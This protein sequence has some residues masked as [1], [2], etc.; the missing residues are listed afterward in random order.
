MNIKITYSWLLEYLDTDAT[1]ADL[2]KYLSLSGPSIERVDKVDSAADGL[3]DYVFDIE[4]TT[5]RIDMASVFGIAQ[6]A[7]AIMPQ[8]GFK[9]KLRINP[10][11]KYT[12]ATMQTNS[13]QTKRLD[14]AIQNPDLC[15]RFT[16]LIFSG[17]KTKPALDIVR[18]RLE[19]IGIKSINNVIDISNYLMVAIGQPTHMF[20]Y[21]K[22]SGGKMIVRESKKGEKLITLDGK[23]LILPGGDIV[24]ED[25][26]GHLIDLCGIMGG[27]N[28]SITAD[29]KTVVFFVQTYDK[30]RLRKT[31]MLTGQRTMA[32]TYFEKGLDPERVENT[33]AY[34]TELLSE[35]TGGT[36]D[37]PLY[38]IYPNPRKEKV[39]HT[40]L[41]DIH[42]V[43]GIPIEE[44]KVITILENLGF[45]VMRTEDPELA[46][47][48]G[49]RLDVAVPT[50]R[51]D[52]VSIKEDITEE[53]ARVYGYGNLPS[54]I[55]PMV[56]VKQPRDIE[57]LFTLQYKTKSLFKY[58]GLNEVLNYSMISENLIVNL[59]LLQQNH[60]KLANTISKEIEYLRLS[61]LPS[62]ALNMKENQGKRDSL[63]FF[64][65]AKVYPK[66]EGD[67]PD[68][69]YKLG[70]AVST[71]FYDLKGIIE[72]M[73]S[74]YH[75]HNYAF[76][77]SSE[78]LFAPQVQAEIVDTNTNKRI[79]IIGKLNRTWKEGM[80][81]DIDSYLAELDFAFITDNYRAVEPYKE[82]L[83]YSVIKLDVNI[84]VKDHTFADIVAQAQ[85]ASDLLIN[86]EYI[87][88]YKDTYTIRFYFSS[89]ERNIT[90]EE[91]K[92]ELEMI[93]KE[94][95]L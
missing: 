45:K 14:I 32:V 70:L 89:P 37:S 40:Y 53:V 42:R 35:M 73:F 75:I 92:K 78:K 15:P 80:E 81:M 10:L 72:T 65:I 74:H 13:T 87:S 6:E 57:R 8:Y 50:F 1:P 52:D 16:A 48:D 71:D 86:T 36:V 62:L 47:P 7:Q 43:M 67:L 90:D 11:T 34:G 77:A 44:K 23:E 94:I 18:S 84:P 17:V 26:S 2:Q 5:N 9:A 85:K 61:L 63:K 12:F 21:D 22:I 41:S 30:R 39:V 25:G 88:T 66:R 31:S 4:I 59:G 19:M 33:I 91:A 56:Y 79:G 83:Q 20:D 69:Q 28:S 27:L 60:L 51:T 58:L 76:K 64:E 68:E 46:Y 3:T 29:T 49:V 93:I 38:D 54:N 55:A 95:S 24:I 82:P